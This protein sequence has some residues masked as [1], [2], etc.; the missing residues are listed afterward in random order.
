MASGSEK[1][2]LRVSSRL[3]RAS[4]GKVKGFR[5]EV[6]GISERPE[7]AGLLKHLARTREGFGRIWPSNDLWSSDCL[8]EPLYL[9]A[10]GNV[11]HFSDSD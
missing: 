1:N 4:A 2:R 11:P 8:S 3:L 7:R 5:A 6:S 10:N 9:L